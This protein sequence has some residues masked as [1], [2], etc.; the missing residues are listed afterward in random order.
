MNRLKKSD[1]LA[2]MNKRETLP[3]DEIGC[4]VVIRPL[5][6]GEMSKVKEL[7]LRGLSS[8]AF[9]KLPL[10]RKKLMMIEAGQDASTLDTGLEAADMIQAQLNEHD[11]NVMAAA[12]GLSCDGETW[13]EE[14]VEKLPPG[15]PDTIADAVFRISGGREEDVAAARKFRGI[16]R[17]GGN[18][19]IVGDGN[20]AG[21]DAS[22]T[23]T[24]A[25]S[26]VA[27]DQSAPAPGT[28]ETD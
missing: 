3:I 21:G 19:D 24:D 13:T 2:G 10:L 12:F 25:G 5:S 7:A 18:P 20:T 6:S 22:G 16:R 26:G 1:I 4:D 15:V 17:G 28:T 8:D 9:R 11:G 23:D 27:V 14:D